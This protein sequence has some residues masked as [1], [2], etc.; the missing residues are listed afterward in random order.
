ATARTPRL[1]RHLVRF[2]DPIREECVGRDAADMD[3]GKGALRDLQPNLVVDQLIIESRAGR[4]FTAGAIIDA[5]DSR[6][7]NFSETHRAGLATGIELASA[8]IEALQ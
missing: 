5:I 2:A 6:P 3:H 1:I 8:Q 7:I 4:V